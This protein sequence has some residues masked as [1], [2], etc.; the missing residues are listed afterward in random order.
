M[1]SRCFAVTVAAAPRGT[2]LVPVPFDPVLT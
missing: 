1:Q 2:L